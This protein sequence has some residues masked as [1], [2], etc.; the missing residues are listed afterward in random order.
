MC[1][2]LNDKLEA[3]IKDTSMH[4]GKGTQVNYI[5]N[6]TII[7]GDANGSLNLDS[8]TKDTIIYLSISDSISKI[9]QKI[10]NTPHNLNGHN[11]VFMFVV[12]DNYKD[13]TTYDINE[14][15]ILDVGNQNILFSNFFNGTLFIFGDFI[16]E[17]EF[18]TKSEQQIKDPIKY[19][20]VNVEGFIKKLYKEK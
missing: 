5:Y 9:N 4:S 11:L 16:R 20:I 14:E 7:S 8:L 2:Y 12:P 3:H 10:K 1:G 15:F 13:K 18:T 19:D 17:N 6:T